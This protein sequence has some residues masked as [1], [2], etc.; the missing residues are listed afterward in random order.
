MSE[1]IHHDIATVLVSEEYQLALNGAKLCVEK[2]QAASIFE[3]KIAAFRATKDSIEFYDR[4][5]RLIREGLTACDE[6]N[7][8][9]KKCQ[10]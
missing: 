10:S 3:D 7:E 1:K 6:E 9:K 5:L 2:F 4:C 8:E